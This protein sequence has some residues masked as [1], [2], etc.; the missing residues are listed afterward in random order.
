MRASVSTSYDYN[1]CG[2]A[3]MNYQGLLFHTFLLQAGK[4]R[5]ERTYLIDVEVLAGSR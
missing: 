4:H 5:R 2:G 1:A 3:L